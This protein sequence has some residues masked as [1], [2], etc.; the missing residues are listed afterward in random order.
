MKKTR[1][2]SGAGLRVVQS[3]RITCS[4]QVA[5]RPGVFAASPGQLVPYILHH[6]TESTK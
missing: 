3:T 1:L 2:L 6:F 4:I 5:P